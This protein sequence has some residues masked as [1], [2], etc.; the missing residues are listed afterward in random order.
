MG[1]PGYAWLENMQNY[2]RMCDPPDYKDIRVTG[3]NPCQPSWAKLITPEGIR[4]LKDVNVGDKIWSEDG[5][6]IVE[7]KWSTGIKKVYKYQT[8]SGTFYGTENHKIVSNSVKIEVE[9]SD[10]IDILTKVFDDSG[11]YSF[12]L[13]DIVDGLVI[14]DGSV[15][16]ASNNLVYLNIGE[17]DKDY[18]S[19]DISKLI[20]KHRPG[21]CKTA[22]EIDTT[23][24][25]EELPILPERT[26]PD[27]FYYGSEDKVTSF[28][29]GLFSANGSIC[30]KRVTL[31]TTC[32]K[33]CEQVKDMLSFL[34]IRSY[35]TTNKPAKVEFENGDYVCKQSYDINICADNDKFLKRIGFIQKYKNEKLESVIQSLVKNNTRAK[36]TYDIVLKEFISEEEVFDITVSGDSHTYW[37]GGCNVSNCLEQSLESYELCNLVETFIDNHDNIADYKRTLKFA[38]LYAKTVT[39]GQTHWKE[40]NRVMLRNR[41]IGCSI[42]GIVQFINSRGLNTLKKWCCEGYTYINSLDEKYSEWL[43]IRP[44]IKKTSIKPSGSVSLLAGATPGLHHPES[45][46]YIRR[47]RLSIHSELIEPLK[48][49]GYKIEECIGSEDST[50]VVEIPVYVGQKLKTVNQASIWEQFSLA[51][52]M[53]KYWAD[54]Q[55]SCTVTFDPE[56]EGNQIEACLNYFQYQLKG[57]SLLPKTDS[58]AYPQMPYEEISEEEYVELSS[59]ISSKIS[60]GSVSGEEA[61]IEKFCD[62]E[63]CMIST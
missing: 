21:L 28:L 56:T 4:Q 35:H 17:K 63:K 50:V 9:Q 20:G 45:L 3:G 53:Q 30:G 59:G 22:Y 47:M 13:Q 40:T 2:S 42:S 41:R 5:W 38:Y 31:K 36:K 6:V 15:H 62:T 23:I 10:S 46:Y 49:A 58:G 12:N 57:I 14:G 19:D 60:F 51:A 25:A 16:R 26:I 24:S 54:N 43:A 52:F 1:E 33:L 11:I 7:N 34:G 48:K 32:Y 39:L 44:S 55:V 37:T 8:T 29:L 61:D 27:R 18:F